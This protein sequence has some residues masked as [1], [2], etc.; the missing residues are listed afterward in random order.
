MAAVS[1][2]PASVTQGAGALVTY[3]KLFGETI[4]AGQAVYL[5]ESDDRWWLAQCDGT[6][7][8]VA[9]R[10]VALNGGAAGQPAAVQT[11]GTL[12]IGGTVAAGIQYAVGRTAGSI[13]PA[14]DLASTDKVTFLGYGTSTSAITVSIQQTGATI[15]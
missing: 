1:I 5:K 8:E 7:A 13:V 12:N 6:A 15:A 10:G 9:A 4:T 3:N 11:G 14:S 2:T